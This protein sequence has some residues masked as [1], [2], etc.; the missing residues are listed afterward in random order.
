MHC[1]WNVWRQPGA[2]IFNVWFFEKSSENFLGICARKVWYLFTTFLFILEYTAAPSE[3]VETRSFQKRIV[4]WE[5][6]AKLELAGFSNKTRHPIIVVG[7]LL[8]N[9][10][11]IAGKKRTSCLT[12]F[13]S[14]KNIRDFQCYSTCDFQQKSRNWCSI[15]AHKCFCRKASSNHWS[16]PSTNGLLGLIMLSKTCQHTCSKWRNKAT[17]YWVLNKQ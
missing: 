14:C 3:T 13:R 9:T 12:V 6:L 15:S 8:D 17:L 2:H 1:W 7:S 5:S 11:N 16:Y 10:P 4:P